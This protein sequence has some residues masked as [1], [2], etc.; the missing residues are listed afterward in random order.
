MGF[1]VVADEVRNLAQ[2]SAQAARETAQRIEDSRTRSARGVELNAKVA[3]SLKEIVDHSRNVD[4]LVAKIA[5]ASQE[6]SQGINQVNLAVTEMDKVTQANAASAEE[7]ASAVKELHG[8]AEVLNRLVDELS[9]MLGGMNQAQ[10]APAKG[11]SVAAAKHSSGA[12]S[13]RPAGTRPEVEAASVNELPMPE[14]PRP[15]ITRTLRVRE[16]GHDKPN[17]G[18]SDMH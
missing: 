2:R 16:N 11:K 10:P 12:E 7:S 15:A 8:E 14:E 18:F 5:Q 6:Q 13:E 1:A 3:R 9:V 4:E 17:G